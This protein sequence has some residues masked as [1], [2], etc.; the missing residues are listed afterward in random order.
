MEADANG[1]ETATLLRA[2]TAD[3]GKHSAGP[4]DIRR[5]PASCCR[6][7][8]ILCVLL[9]SGNLN[10]CNARDLNLCTVGIAL[11]GCEVL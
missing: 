8:L 10:V 3:N 11:T 5:N 7:G 6:L 1:L 9:C 4:G 2:C